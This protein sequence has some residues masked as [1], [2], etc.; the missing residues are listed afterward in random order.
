M[1]KLSAKSLKVM[2]PMASS[3]ATDVDAD[4]RGSF[5]TDGDEPVGATHFEVTPY[6]E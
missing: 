6:A 4:G 2:H 1:G 3:P 5:R